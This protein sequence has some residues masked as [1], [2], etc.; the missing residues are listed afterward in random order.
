MAPPNPKP[1]SKEDLHQTFIDT[2]QYLTE[3]Q[4]KILEKLN[5][6]EAKIVILE[7]EAAKENSL[8]NS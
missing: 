7:T 1:N 2:L 5:V 4:S 3:V 6:I 8:N